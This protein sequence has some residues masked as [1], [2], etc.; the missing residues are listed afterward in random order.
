MVILLKTVC[1]H[2][3]RLSDLLTVLFKPI[4]KELVKVLSLLNPIMRKEFVFIFN[5]Q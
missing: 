5:A 1:C 3:D 4:L 2:T